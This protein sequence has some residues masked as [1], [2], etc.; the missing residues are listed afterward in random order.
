MSDAAKMN[1]VEF[2]E[3]VLG[4]ELLDFQKRYLTLLYDVYE[5]D[6]ETFNKLTFPCRIGSERFDARILYAVIFSI[7]NEE[8]E[9][10]HKNSCEEWLPQYEGKFVKEDENG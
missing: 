9:S 8:I 6:K 3:K 4:L 2:V 5:K 7:F 1:I 10:F